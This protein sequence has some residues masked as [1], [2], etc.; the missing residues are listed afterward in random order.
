MS[1]TPRLDIDGIPEPFVLQAAIL[2]GRIERNPTLA[3]YHLD[4][5][6]DEPDLPLDSLQNRLGEQGADEVIGYRTLL[7]SGL[8]RVLSY[9]QQT[10]RA[11]DQ[12]ERHQKLLSEHRSGRLHGVTAEQ[13]RLR[14]RASELYH[15]AGR[16]AAEQHG[17]QVLSKEAAGQRLQSA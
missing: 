9:D 17:T 7:T 2:E 10:N 13:H 4:I 6:I 15:Y 14:I 12:D 5:L 16:V 8:Y 3:Q 1:E 11:I